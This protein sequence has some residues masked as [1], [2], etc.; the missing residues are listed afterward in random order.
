VLLDIS[1]SGYI[2]ILIFGHRGDVE[3][4]L[5]FYNKLMGSVSKVIRNKTFLIYTENND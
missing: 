2:K 1:L 4:K 3:T 5:V